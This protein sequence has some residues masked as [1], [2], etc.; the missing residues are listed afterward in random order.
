VPDEKV[1]QVMAVLWAQ[2][3]AQLKPSD[4]NVA[5]IQ[6]SPKLLAAVKEI[7]QALQ[8]TVEKRTGISMKAQPNIVYIPAKPGC[9]VP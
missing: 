2:Q 7:V 8:I 6:D 1:V 4:M 9:L 5:K 3:A